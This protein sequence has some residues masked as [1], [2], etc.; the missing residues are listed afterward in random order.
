[1]DI[2]RNGIVAFATGSPQD[3]IQTLNLETGKATPA[4]E[5]MGSF[6]P[7]G[8]WHAY[9]SND[10]G[11]DEVYVRPFPRTESA[12]RLVSIGGGSG[13]VWAP[14]GS[15]LYYRGSSGDMM[16]VPVT[17]SP[18]SPPAAR[19]R[20]SALPASIACREPRRRTTS[21][22]MASASSWCPSARTPPRPRVNRS[23]SCST[24]S[25]SSAGLARTTH[26]DLGRRGYTGKAP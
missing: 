11:R 14:N 4:R 2:S 7:D 15:T 21:I 12:A 19:G 8:R 23:I 5:H 22:P 6:S 1:M 20:C 10:S 9:T 24:G 3:D 17:L 18:T 26:A 25:R 13:P 16:S